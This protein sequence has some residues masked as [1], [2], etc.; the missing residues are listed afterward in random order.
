MLGLLGVVVRVALI[1][2]AVLGVLHIV[3]AAPLYLQLGDLHHK[4]GVVCLLIVSVHGELGVDH[5]V[6][7]HTKGLRD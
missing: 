7:I 5:L 2:A 6:A 4:F 1:A 3:V